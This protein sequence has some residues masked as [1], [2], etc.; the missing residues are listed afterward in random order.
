MELLIIVAILITITLCVL[1]FFGVKEKRKY[2]SVLDEFEEKISF[3]IVVILFVSCSKDLSYEKTCGTIEEKKVRIH[4]FIIVSGGKE[5]N[6]SA[7]DWGKYK[8]GDIFCR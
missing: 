1:I 3:F 7:L 2:P 8:V 5:Y 4:E 6:V